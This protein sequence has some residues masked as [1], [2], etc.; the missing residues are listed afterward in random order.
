MDEKQASRV[1]QCSIIIRSYY[2]PRSFSP[3][4]SQ[5]RVYPP[6]GY[7]SGRNTPPSQSPFYPMVE[8]TPSASRPISDLDLEH[9]VQDVL[10]SANL[11]S[12]WG[13]R[14]Q[15]KAVINAAIDCTLLGVVR[16]METITTFPMWHYKFQ[17][18][19]LCALPVSCIYDL[20]V[21]PFFFLIY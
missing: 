14:H 5:H 18:L 13:I 15:L 11:N 20:S 1:S 10:R 7:R 8:T 3:A 17:D 2:E 19:A 21:W 9:A 12:K 6:P 16:G 4:P